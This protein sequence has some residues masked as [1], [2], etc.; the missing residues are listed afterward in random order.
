MFENE[1]N[2]GTKIKRVSQKEGKEKILSYDKIFVSLE[3]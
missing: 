2:L 1:G 3:V